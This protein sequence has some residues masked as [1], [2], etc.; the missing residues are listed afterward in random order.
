MHLS[1]NITFLRQWPM[2]H[3]VVWGLITIFQ[4]TV[5]P[6]WWCIIDHCSIGLVSCLPFLLQLCTE[7]TFPMCFFPTVTPFCLWSACW[8]QHPSPT[9]ALCSQTNYFSFST[10]SSICHLLAHQLNDPNPFW[11][12][13]HCSVSLCASSS[14]I[15]PVEISCTQCSAEAQ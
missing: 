15:Q 2:L 1:P 9:F 6:L 12:H 7:V 5:L 14:T 10:P 8:M 11:I 4:R 3:A 13:L